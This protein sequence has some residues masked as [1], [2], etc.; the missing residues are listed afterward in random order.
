MAGGER[1]G[2]VFVIYVGF[3]SVDVLECNPEYVT[4]NKNRI[5]VNVMPEKH[6]SCY[7]DEIQ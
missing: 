5:Y 2:L 4:Y 3:E 1:L 7:A 6:K